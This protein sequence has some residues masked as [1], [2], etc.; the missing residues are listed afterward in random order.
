MDDLPAVRSAH[1]SDVI[2]QFVE[3]KEAAEGAAAEEFKGK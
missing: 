1:L 3:E 2:L